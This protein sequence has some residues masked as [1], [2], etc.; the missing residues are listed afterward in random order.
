MK[1]RNFASKPLRVF[2]LADPRTRARA[3][4]SLI[5][6]FACLA[7][8]SCSLWV[9]GTDS[10]GAST[11]TFSITYNANLADSGT[12]PV[13]SQEYKTGATARVAVNTGAL[14]RTGYIFAGWNSAADGSGT[15][16]SAESSASF[17]MGSADVVLYALWQA[18]GSI[19]YVANGA[20][21]GAVPVDDTVYQNGVSAPVKGNSG[22][23]AQA[24]YGLL[25]WNTKPDGTGT[26]Y[27]AD[28]SATMAMTGAYVKLYAIWTMIDYT[29]TYDANG[30]TGERYPF[31]PSIIS[32]KRS[33]C[34][35]IAGA[36]LW[37]EITSA[38]GRP[39]R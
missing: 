13:D 11:T 39:V 23:L 37:R 1:K 30:A 32:V 25:N 15:T 7:V 8:S 26:A 17:V 27:A 9:S 22:N 31:R 38:D 10:N 14:A 4:I 19:V 5:I 21:D 12:V 16:Y 6:L 18:T 35:E 29:V 24:G 28:G 20:T 33:R 2:F 3:A 34:R 36:S